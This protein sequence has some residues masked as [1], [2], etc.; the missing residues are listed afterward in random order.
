MI[1]VTAYRENNFLLIRLLAA[2][3]VL[4][5]H[6]FEHFS[7]TQI[8]YQSVEKLIWNF[9]GVNVFFIISGYLIFQSAERN[10]ITAFFPKRVKRIYPALIVCFVVTVL[11]LLAFKSLRLVDIFSKDFLMW[12]VAQTTFFQ[13][14]NPEL[15]RDFGFSPPNGALW[16]IAVELQFYA[17]TMLFW[18]AFLRKR[19]KL[20]RNITLFVIFI[21]SALFNLYYRTHFPAESMLYKLSFVF[22]LSYLYIF[23]VGALVY[24]NK[25][26]VLRFFK[27]KALVW[28]VIFIAVSLL[29]NH[30]QLRYNR[31]AFNAL[32]LAM[33]LLLTGLVF[34]VAYTK[35][36]FSN[37]LFKGNDF[38]YGIYLYQMLVLNIFFQ[39]KWNNSLLGLLAS[40]TICILFGI[41]SWFG[42]EKRFLKL[43]A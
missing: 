2:L 14:Y 30:F 28:I 12:L 29:L 11:I 4:V 38:S 1:Q 5:L 23:V 40:I 3:Q 43:S 35:P 10:S 9:P 31:Y 15:V 8:S 36:S 26:V 6:H 18:Y 22:V 13:F 7:L 32:S 16:T 20:A 24:L 21:I 37:Q 17:F 34:S 25:S 33:L 41:I 27:G 19:S 42:I 39:M